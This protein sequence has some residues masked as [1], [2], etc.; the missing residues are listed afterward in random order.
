MS[1]LK[2]FLLCFFT[3]VCCG[4]EASTQIGIWEYATDQVIRVIESVTWP[5]VRVYTH[6]PLT[7]GQCVK[8]KNCWK[9]LSLAAR[10]GN[11]TV[12]DVPAF[13]LPSL[14]QTLMDFVC[15]KSVY[16]STTLSVN[17][18]LVHLL[19]VLIPLTYHVPPF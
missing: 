2:P 3:E 12:A 9:A 5:C 16:G 11:R 8:N 18:R 10:Y 4:P 19:A 15:C 13:C 17:S 7:R 6:K 14:Q 1:M